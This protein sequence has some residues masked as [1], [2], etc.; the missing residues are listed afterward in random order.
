MR[1]N[2]FDVNLLTKG[3]MNLPS[4]LQSMGYSSL[5]EEQK[6]P[7]NSILSGKDTFVI[8][9]TG[10]GKTLLYTATTKALNFKTIV[11]SPLI[12]LQRDQTQSIN[13][14]GIKAGSVNSDNSEAMNTMT[15]N[16]WAMGKL[17]ILFIA[18]ERITTPAFKQAIAQQPPDMVALDEAHTMS[19]WGND[20]RP[21]Y[22]RC[23]DF[24]KEQNPR[25]V[26]ALTATATEKIVEDVREVL[27]IHDCN[28]CC[29]YSPRTNLKLSSSFTPSENLFSAVLNKVRSID[30][31][32]IIYCDTIK[33]LS[34]LA[35]FLSAA[36]EDV[37]VYHS[38][39]NEETKAENQN[40]FM[41]DSIRIMLCTNA[42]GMGIDKPNIRGII[43]AWP[44]GSI[45]A[46]AQ[47]TGRASRDGEEATCHMFFTEQGMSQHAFFC[48][49]STP[50]SNTAYTCWKVVTENKDSND[51]VF[52]TGKQMEK[53]SGGLVG[54]ENIL[55][56][57][58]SIGCVDRYDLEVKTWEI[59]VF[60]DPEKKIHKATLDALIEGGTIVRTTSSGYKVY[61]TTLEYAATTLLKGVPTIRTHI[62]ALVKEGAIAATPPFAGK[63][64]KVL[65]E[66]T[67]VDYMILDERRRQKQDQF[68][69]VTK[70]HN[71][72]DKDKWKFITDYFEL[73]NLIKPT[74][75]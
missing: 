37:T 35:S 56:V 21:A 6:D 12:A 10:G 26:I 1:E 69:E 45:E 36:G 25:V 2:K 11:F 4:V 18:P 17:D 9:P 8:I 44:P 71:T 30:G 39:L 42:F 14:K 55:N 24:V 74:N 58:H 40:N 33:H 43:H 61:E 59:T 29:N 32:V 28:I 68:K 47:E 22:K 62:N 20:F 57:F 38:Q 73:K 23:G 70:Y 53:L 13:L 66:P 54:S 49:L 31:S 64:T 65:R 27:G 51:E 67:K 19:Q 75:G 3:L 16:E 50:D 46:I 72:P 52:L 63:V 7:I 15:L 5:R 41:S 34:D 48:D 60:K